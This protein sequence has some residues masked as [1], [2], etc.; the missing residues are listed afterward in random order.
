M[1]P[2]PRTG[3]LDPGLDEQLVARCRSGE[4]SAWEALVRRHQRLVYG[5]ARS[6]RLADEDLADVFQEV[7]AALLRALDRLRDGRA[8]VRW[9]SVTTD[10]IARTTALKRRREQALTRARD[11]AGGDP[12]DRI[13]DPGEPV[14]ADLERLE[15]EATLRM[16][17]ATVPERCRRL[18]QALYYDDPVPGYAELAER[19]GVPIGSLGPTRA[20]CFEKMRLAFEELANPG[21]RHGAAPTSLDEDTP[22]DTPR[23]ASGRSRH[24]VSEECR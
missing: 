3:G 13:A 7:F 1:T 15:R 12:L 18:L 19:L 21:I 4:A 22:R 24:V 9:L 11:D 8:L 10:R 20:R 5:V 17:L 6:Y 16:A 2:T 23:A 14:G